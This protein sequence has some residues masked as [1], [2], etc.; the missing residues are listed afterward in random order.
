MSIVYAIF[1]VLCVLTAFFLVFP[2]LMVFF[3][4]FTKESIK[5]I[6]QED[7]NFKAYDY[8][9]IITAYKNAEIAKPLIQSL[10]RQKYQNHHVYL[11]ADECDISDWDLSH[12]MLTV[13]NPQPPL[14]L[15]AKSII[16]AVKHFVREH[17]YIA[18]F[19][20]LFIG[21]TF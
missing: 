13:L 14:R 18:I 2:F 1:L 5:E 6:N 16:H 4:R 10:I 8:A 9:C 3:S 12:D 7:S 20:N 15:K 21:R 11:V 19:K 17:D